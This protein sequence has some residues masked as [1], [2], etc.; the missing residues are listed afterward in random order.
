MLTDIEKQNARPLPIFKPELRKAIREGRKTQT[1]RV[2]KLKPGEEVDNGE[3]WTADDPYR[4][5]NCPYG[6]PGD[7]AYLRE[8][9]RRDHEGGIQYA[10]DGASEIDLESLDGFT[11]WKWKRSTLPSIHMPRWAARKFVR[12]TEICVERLQDISESDAIAEGV[13]DWIDQHQTPFCRRNYAEFDSSGVC[14]EPES[15]NCD[16]YSYVEHFAELWKSINGADSWAA[17]P[18]VWVVEWEVIE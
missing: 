5:K 14:T 10:D 15:C 12:I 3:A 7:I 18:W 16:G 1:R 13:D 4:M 17:N 2:L 11:K 6:K 8:P 9:L